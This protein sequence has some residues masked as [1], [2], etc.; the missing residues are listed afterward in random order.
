MK[1]EQRVHVDIGKSVSVGQEKLLILYVFAHALEAAS[2]HGLFPCIDEG[3]APRFGAALV[4]VHFVLS[5]VE[6][7][8]ASVQ[9]VIGKVAFDHVPTITAANHEVVYSGC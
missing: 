9:K 7:E 4:D 6:C 1:G 8:V 3:D 2:R 5:D